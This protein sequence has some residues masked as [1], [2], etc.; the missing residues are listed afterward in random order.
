MGGGPGAERGDRSHQPVHARRGPGGQAGD[1]SG[2][3]RGGRVFSLRSPLGVP[4]S[5][6]ARPPPEPWPL[7]AD[8]AER[9]PAFQPGTRAAVGG[10]RQPV[11]VFRSSGPTVAADVA[12]SSSGSDRARWSRRRPRSSRRRPRSSDPKRPVDRRKRRRSDCGKSWRRCADRGQA[13][14]TDGAASLESRLQAAHSP[15]SCRDSQ[16]SI[17][18]PNR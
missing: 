16:S 5:D 2:R 7:R 10:R 9:R 8:F 13:K 12:G 4:E 11:A 17:H 18:P 15:N 14:K 1:L 6:L 3:N